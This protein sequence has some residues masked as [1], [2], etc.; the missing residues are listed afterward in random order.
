MSGNGVEERNKNDEKW[1]I[2][3]N[4]TIHIVISRCPADEST[5]KTFSF[6][7]GSRETVTFTFRLFDNADGERNAAPTT[8][9]PG[10]FIKNDRIAEIVVEQ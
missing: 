8:I 1:I 5:E 3:T 9:F 10:N 2:R 7:Y 6:I 4:A